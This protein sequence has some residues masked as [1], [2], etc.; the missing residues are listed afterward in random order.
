MYAHFEAIA[1]DTRLPIVLYN[2]PGRTAADLADDT[3]L[4]LA[5]DIESI[6]GIKDATGDLERG[7]YL[8]EHRPADFLVI[9]GD[10]GTALDLTLMGGQ[11]D[12]SVT[13]NVAP[14]LMSQA[15]EYALAGDEAAA[16][17]C[18]AKLAGL[19]RALFIESSPSPAKYCLS[20]IGMIANHVRLP[21]VTTDAQHYPLL[22]QAMMQAE[23]LTQETV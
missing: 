4:A 20:R 12:I 2:V 3:A 13:A 8:L 23:L 22:E 11:G 21:L 9:S 15:M 17:A 16:K 10:D 7:R 1:N 14:A 6:V 18:D 19:H 5:R